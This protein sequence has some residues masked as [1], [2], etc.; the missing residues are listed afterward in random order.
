M[1]G[2]M[3]VVIAKLTSTHH[4]GRVCMGDRTKGLVQRHSYVHKA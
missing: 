2:I 1:V 3:K 4:K